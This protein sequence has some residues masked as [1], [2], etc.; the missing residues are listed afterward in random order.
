MG[1]G[2][3]LTID[4]WFFHWFEDEKKYKSVTKLFIQILE[5]CDKI[6]LQKGTRHNTKFETLAEKSAYYPKIQRDAVKVL[7]NLFLRNSDKIHYVDNTEEIENTLK[8]KLPRKDVYLVE[9]SLSANSKYFIT[10]DLTLF[11]N[12]N[13]TF[14]E[15]GIKAFMADDFIAK[16]PNFME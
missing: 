12:L 16:Y 4:E 13:E 9:M 11:E 3:H 7:M 1:R 6:V 2:L 14:N 15:L 5:V 10:T 8:E